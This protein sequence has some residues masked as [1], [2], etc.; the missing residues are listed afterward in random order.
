MDIVG[1]EHLHLLWG[2]LFWSLCSIKPL[3]GAKSCGKVEK[4]LVHLDRGR[5]YG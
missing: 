3:P 1:F 4:N 2:K 5:F